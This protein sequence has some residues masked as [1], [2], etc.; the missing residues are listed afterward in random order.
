M[1]E[2]NKAVRQQ[3]QREQQAQQEIEAKFAQKVDEFRTCIHDQRYAEAELVAKQAEQ[4]KPNDPVSTMLVEESKLMRHVAENRDVK[5]RKEEGFMAA[6]HSVNEAGIPFDDANPYTFP[7]AKTWKGLSD[8]R[9]RL[10]KEM[11]RRGGEREIEIRQKLKTPVALQFEQVAVDPGDQ[12][13]GQ[14]RRHQHLL[15]PARACRGGDHHRHPGDDRP[16]AGSQAGR[17]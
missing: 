17:R 3:I 14:D 16:P 4:L 6:L 8:R 2:Q 9:L 13:P 12:L 15:R 5:E 7:D 11:G 10:A 1:D